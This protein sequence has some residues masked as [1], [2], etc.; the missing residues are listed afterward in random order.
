MICLIPIK[1]RKKIS[2]L[3]RYFVIVNQSL[4]IKVLKHTMHSSKPWQNK[5]QNWQWPLGAL[6]YVEILFN[7]LCHPS[8]ISIQMK[9]YNNKE[10]SFYL[11]QRS[12]NGEDG[13]L[14]RT[15]KFYI[16]YLTTYKHIVFSLTTYIIYT[17]IST[18]FLH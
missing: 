1:R 9:L 18:L 6:T 13:K 10:S 8:S 17:L 12:Y 16:K 15:R 14:Q 7:H 5:N 3:P 2:P 11:F 4:V